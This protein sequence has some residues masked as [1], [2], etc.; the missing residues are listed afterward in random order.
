MASLHPGEIDVQERFSSSFSLDRIVFKKVQNALFDHIRVLQIVNPWT[1]TRMHICGGS[2]IN[3]RWI[4]TAA[5]CVD[6]R[7]SMSSYYIVAGAQYA[8]RKEEST[9]E[10]T[11]E[12]IVVHPNRD[13]E[14]VEV[15]LRSP[16]QCS[17]TYAL[18][19]T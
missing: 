10:R 4:V 19:G 11:V 6:S 1:K 5:H 17:R 12:K 2:I 15:R 8:M 14:S 7:V 16:D 9:Q 3:D 13:A 18:I